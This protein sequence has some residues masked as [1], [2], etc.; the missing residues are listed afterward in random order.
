MLSEYRP[1]IVIIDDSP[2]VIQILMQTLLSD[3]RVIPFGSAFEGIEYLKKEPD[4][5][6]VILDI[7][8]P[9]I[10]GYQV[11]DFI[12]G[13]PALVDVPVIFVTAR[14]DVES[15]ICAFDLGITDYIK[16]PVIPVIAKKRIDYHISNRRKSKLHSAEKASIKKLTEVTIK[17][18]ISLVGFFDDDSESHVNRIMEY[19]T[20]IAEKLMQI[21]KYKETLTPQYIE[22]IRLAAPFHDCGKVFI[23]EQ[24][25]TKPEKLTPEEFEQIKEHVIFGSK[26]MQKAKNLM[27]QPS[28]YDLA[29]KLVLYYHEKWDG[30]G[31]PAKLKGEE[32]PLCAR[33]MTFADVYDAL[34]SARPYRPAFTHEQ[35]VDIIFSGRGK[36]FDP[37]ICDVFLSLESDFKTIMQ[38]IRNS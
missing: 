25:L 33:I 12:K 21:P 19:V 10:S 13:V 1:S 34:V 20:L 24:L 23:S 35:A 30:T 26:L 5:D 27:G 28:F 29:E 6:L 37:D 7:D 8:M 22:N 38:T 31:Y 15:E 16:K 36:T 18:I 3:Y 14:T 17:T 4:V 9:A 11:F 2:I 32:I